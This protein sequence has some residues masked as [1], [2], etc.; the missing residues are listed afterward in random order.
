MRQRKWAVER[1]RRVQA[2]SQFISRFLKLDVSEQLVR[3][4]IICWLY[5]KIRPVEILPEL[6]HFY[7]YICLFVCFFVP[8]F[9]YVNQ[10]FAPSPDQDVGALFDVSKPRELFQVPL[11]NTVIFHKL[12]LKCRTMWTVSFTGS[13]LFLC[14]IHYLH[15]ITRKLIR[16]SGELFFFIHKKMCVREYNSHTHLILLWHLIIQKDYVYIAHVML[17]PLEGALRKRMPKFVSAD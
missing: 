5:K 15:S 4:K 3:M 2:L 7:N 1:G 13:Q 9:I 10:S 16:K 17:W 11:G 14:R 8:Q 6:F 12:N